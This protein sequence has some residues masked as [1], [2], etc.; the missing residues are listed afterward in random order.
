MIGDLLQ[1]PL[2]FKCAAGGQKL[3][4]QF[5]HVTVQILQL[6]DPIL[7]I[8]KLS[9]AELVLF[10]DNKTQNFKHLKPFLTYIIPI[11]RGHQP[12]QLLNH[13]ICIFRQDSATNPFFKLSTGLAAVSLPVRV[14]HN[15]AQKIVER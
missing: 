12:L 15:L 14:F 13:L 1:L 9:V 8:W 10:P 2:L 6:F 11:Y 3:L 5:V 4:H 7:Y